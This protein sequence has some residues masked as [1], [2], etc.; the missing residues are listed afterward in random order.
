MRFNYLE[1]IAIGLIILG[2]VLA[3]QIYYNEKHGE[4]SS[5]PLVYAAK[6]YEEKT[7]YEFIGTGYFLINGES[8][9]VSFSSYGVDVSFPESSK[10]LDFPINISALD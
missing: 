9:R 1:V 2:G 4:C 7:G 6:L 8:P 3:M 10:G 5:D